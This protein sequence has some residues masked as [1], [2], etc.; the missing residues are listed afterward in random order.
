MLDTDAELTDDTETSK[1]ELVDEVGVVLEDVT[2]V[3]L[4]SAIDVELE[5]TLVVENGVADVEELVDEFGS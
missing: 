2:W 3:E 1:E 4:A 5:V